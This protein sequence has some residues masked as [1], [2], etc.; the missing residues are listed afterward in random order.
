MG[1]V[2]Y[3]HL[4]VGGKAAKFGQGGV[5]WLAAGKCQ[6][7]SVH[8]TLTVGG[9]NQRNYTYDAAA[10]LNTVTADAHL[11]GGQDAGAV[12]LFNAP[13]YDA[14]GQLTAAGLAFNSTSGT[15]MIGLTRGYDNRLRPVSESDSGQV[16]TPGTPATVTVDVSGT[17]QSI[18]SGTPVAATGTV[19]L[20]Y[21]G[22][23]QGM[24]RAQPLLVSSSITLPNGYHTSFVA[25]ATSAVGTA[26]AI[27]NAL[28]QVTSPVTA[29]VAA[30]GTASAASVTLT[31][32]VT[33]A[34]QNGTITVHL[35][36]TQVTAAPASMSGG[37]GATYDTGTVTATVG[38]TNFTVNYGQTSTAATVA[39]ALASAITAG[40]LG[41]TAT[42]GANG[43]L[44]VTANA[45][46]T[47]D[48]GIAVTLNSS[49]SEPSLFSS[50]SF[51]GTSGS[52]GGGADATM[53]P[54]TIYS[55]TIPAPGAPAGYDGVG[56]VLSFA[57]LVNGQWT[58]IGYNTL[59]Q[60]ITATVSGT[61]STT[62]TWSYDPFGNRKTQGPDG[63][64]LVYPP[65]N[66]RIQGYGYD[67]SGNVTDD[68]SNQYAY[69]AEG[70]LCVVYNKTLTTWTG[71]AYDG[72]GNRVMTGGGVNSLSC[73][74]NLTPNTTFIVGQNGELL[75]SL[76]ASG[77]GFSNVFAHGQLLATYQFPTSSWTFA[78][79]DWLGTKR[80]VADTNG[81]MVETCTG[82]PFGDGVNCTGPGGDPG[83]LHFTG[84]PR[85]LESGNDYFG[86]RY[87]SSPT[88]RFLSPDWSSDPDAVPYADLED[89]QTLNLYG[90]VRNNP[91]SK[92]DPDGHFMLVQQD[93]WCEQAAQ[94]ILTLWYNLE[95][96][97]QNHWFKSKQPV[98]PPPALPSAPNTANPNPDDGSNPDDKKKDQ[99]E[100]AKSGARD[101]KLTNTEIQNLKENTGR[102]AEEI[103]TDA[104][105]TKSV[106]KYDLF[107]NADGEIVAKPKGSSGTGEPTGYTTD[108]LK[109][110][111][112]SSPED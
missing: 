54:G 87:Y 22:G 53:T 58:Q 38:S 79:N 16:G 110:S 17:E 36:A 109:A 98:P 3:S 112:A 57:D 42:T 69:D 88:G 71:Y 26:N 11:V 48:N 66:N 2:C 41:V 103:K 101:K 30:G 31:S 8:V 64:T 77:A 89:P 50:P 86:A 85:D 12:T 95:W 13:S 55:Y 111:K 104:L 61:P 40:Q 10:Q 76:N 32:K 29:A 25:S 20:S 92:T 59:N 28:N 37:S 93:C 1:C 81:E 24:L 9:T 63:G 56:N 33:G 83:P 23:E 91:L 39:S 94:N 67:A 74:N 6:V 4:S 21:S 52:L 45:P 105:G 97:W 84:K 107:K 27:A 78:L 35:V 65:G 60:L 49:T 43:A 90:Y 18:G 34:S 44:T 14:A 47:T 5:K 82:F 72:L 99:K 106:G 62:L 46:G 108:D 15:S 19:S 102:S 96:N 7:R 100:T 75:D 70:R 68:G 51:S 73:D 80:F